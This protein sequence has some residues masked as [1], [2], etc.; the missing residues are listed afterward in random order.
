MQGAEY[1][2]TLQGRIGWPSDKQY[3]DALSTPGT[4]F[5]C[6][7][8]QEDMTRVNDI[9]VNI[10]APVLAKDRFYVDS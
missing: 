2:R 9:R 4:F 10:E 3:K 8:I 5:N 6:P 1:A 7:I